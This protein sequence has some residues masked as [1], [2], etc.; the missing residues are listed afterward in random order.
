MSK[1]YGFRGGLRTGTAFTAPTMAAYADDEKDD[2]QSAQSIRTAVLKQQV[3]D[4]LSAPLRREVQLAKAKLDPI[5][6]IN[7]RLGAK[8][9]ALAKS[10]KSIQDIVN[11]AVGAGKSGAE[12]A[13]LTRDATDA[14]KRLADVEVNLKVPGFNSAIA[15]DSVGLEPPVR[16]MKK[17]AAKK[18]KA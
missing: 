14:H 6:T 1:K 8:A 5:G 11:A 16:T 2:L 10:Q 7:A 13:Q 17:R 18:A 12:L 4:E 15:W 3:Y 9:A